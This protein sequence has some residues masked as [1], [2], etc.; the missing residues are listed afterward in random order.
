MKTKFELTGTD[1]KY[2]AILA[3]T[4]DHTALLFLSPDNVLYL[5]T[6]WKHLDIMG[7]IMF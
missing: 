2:I 6:F 3:M 1:L 4:I 7:W 5:S